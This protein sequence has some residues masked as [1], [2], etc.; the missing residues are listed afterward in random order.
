MVRP[1]M[2]P[3]ALLV[4]SSTLAQSDS[5]SQETP[6]L[7]QMMA[8]AMKS[9]APMP[10]HDLLRKLAG[11][12]TYV[13][14]MTMPGMP[15]MHGAGTTSIR[16]ILGGRFVEF[17]STSENM[18]PPVASMGILG[19][20][21]RKGKEEYF[22]LWVDTLGHYYIDPRGKWNDETAALVLH[23]EEFDPSTGVMSPFRQVFRFLGENT[24]T[25]EVYITIPGS[26]ED[27]RM[28]GIVYQRARTREVVDPPS[29]PLANQLAEMRGQGGGLPSYSAAD[30]EEMDR[31]SLQGAMIEIMRARTMTGIEDASRVRLDAQYSTALERLRTMQVGDKHALGTEP[32]DNI[33]V[34]EVPAFT[35]EIISE[36]ST[37]EAVN[38]LRQIA[39]S[40]RN[41]ALSEADQETLKDLFEQVFEHLREQRDKEMSLPTGNSGSQN[42]SEENEE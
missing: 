5:S 2:L 40:R 31:K 12:W 19:Y 3:L 34:H 1:M 25:C 18:D 27:L 24:M 42:E 38:A 22:A 30:I 37:Q 11:D 13:V 16:E 26:H 17:R 10:E 23:G 15:T 9:T 28:V 14:E 8:E 21:S 39:L 29:H 4:C 6:S 41:P 36:M 33:Q 7:H 32:G 35:Q 20:D